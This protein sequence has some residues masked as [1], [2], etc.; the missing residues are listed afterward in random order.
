MKFY[1]LKTT[2]RQTDTHLGGGGT[3]ELKSEAEEP[4]DCA[5]DQARTDEDLN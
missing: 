3:S 2:D 1:A 4:S 5:D